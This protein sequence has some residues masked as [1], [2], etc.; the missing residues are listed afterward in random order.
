MVLEYPLPGSWSP[1]SPQLEAFAQNF[2]SPDF[3]KAMHPGPNTSVRMKEVA[4]T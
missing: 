1:A 3:L 2:R 4:R